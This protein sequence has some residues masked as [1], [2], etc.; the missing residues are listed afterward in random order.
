M[1]DKKRLLV[2]GA[3]GHAKVVIATAQAAGWEVVGLFDDDSALKG[4]TVLGAPVIGG[5]EL[6]TNLEVDGAVV[7]IGG[8][9]AR[10]QLSEKL[11]LPWATISHPSAEIHHTVVL[12]EGAVVFAGA[13][14]Q[15]DST[16][17]R[18]AIVNTAA[19][20]DHDCVVGDFAHLAP[21]THLAGSVNV[22]EGALLGIGASVIPGMKI[23]KWSIVGAGA[24]VTNDVPGGVTAVG[25]PSKVT[26]WRS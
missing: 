4:T 1:S 10:M 19:S 14:I 6:A 7:A 13:V 2:I 11:A 5:T 18:H 16:I 21:G 17:G 25:V 23:G 8:S 24:A 12:G 20:V 3:G 15:P 26:E 9:R 22:G